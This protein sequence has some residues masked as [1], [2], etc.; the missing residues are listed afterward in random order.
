MSKKKLKDPR[1]TIVIHHTDDGTSPLWASEMVKGVKLPLPTYSVETE[2]SKFFL[3]KQYL[4]VTKD[5]QIENCKLD[6]LIVTHE[7]EVVFVIGKHSK[8]G[9]IGEVLSKHRFLALYAPI[10]LSVGERVRKLTT[11][12][13]KEIS[14][15][16]DDKYSR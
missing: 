14:K 2:E 9:E 11:K 1:G 16:L 8:V 7:D 4:L 6:Y 5:V 3:G 13:L 12:D 15:K 10:E